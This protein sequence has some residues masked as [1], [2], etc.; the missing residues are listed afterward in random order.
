M[1]VVLKGEKNDLVVSDDQIGGE[2]S[3]SVASIETHSMRV[4][5]HVHIAL[6][7]RARA[8]AAPDRHAGCCRQ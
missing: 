1:T 4:H 6:S 8:A 7:G 3:G 2:G 5:I